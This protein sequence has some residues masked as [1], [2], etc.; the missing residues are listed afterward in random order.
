MVEGTVTSI[1]TVIGKLGLKGISAAAQSSRKVLFSECCNWLKM[2]VQL[3]KS[4]CSCGLSG[5]TVICARLRPALQEDARIQHMDTADGSHMLLTE[6]QVSLCKV[7]IFFFPRLIK[8]GCFKYRFSTLPPS[9]L[10]ITKVGICY[11]SSDGFIRLI[12]CQKLIT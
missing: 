10:N 2:H 1:L 11:C 6:N 9:E 3:K 5:N 4:S 12:L 8:L 7:F